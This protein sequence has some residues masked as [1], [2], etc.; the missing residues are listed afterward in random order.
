MSMTSV[1]LVGTADGPMRYVDA[2]DTAVPTFTTKAKNKLDYHVPLEYRG[3]YSPKDLPNYDP[4]YKYR[5]DAYGK[6]LCEGVT[7]SGVSCGKRSVNRAL[8]CEWHGGGLHPNDRV[9]KQSDTRAE[10]DLSRYEQFKRGI[11]TVEDL[12]DDE[13][14][15]CAFRSKDGR[16]YAPK[17]MPREL[18]QEFNKALYRRADIEMKKHTV[19]SVKAVAEIMQS[20]AV[21]PE[22]RLKAATFLIERNL[23]KTP[24]VIAF[25]TT[26]PWEEVFDDIAHNRIRAIEQDAPIEAEVITED[27]SA[28]VRILP[29][30][31]VTQ[32]LAVEDDLYKSR[33]GIPLIEVPDV[34]TISVKESLK[35][36]N[37]AIMAQET[38]VKEFTYDLN[39]HATQ[40]KAERR[41]RYIAR[42]MGNTQVDQPAYPLRRITEVRFT[43]NVLKWVDERRVHHPNGD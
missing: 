18:M 39:D 41:K 6:A 31:D 42:A 19:D 32:A 22:V 40:V 12:E 20:T 34:E 10:A 9:L 16:L 37:P 43:G 2:L 23:G 29:D 27:E 30:E 26:A 14:A 25:Q 4:K 11:I 5:V 38:E 8:Y 1:E 33:N 15:A 35:T 13:L 7:K 21:E 3:D 28:S 17:N 24:Q 36:R